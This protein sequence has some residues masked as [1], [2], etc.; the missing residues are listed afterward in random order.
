MMNAKATPKPKATPSPTPKTRV[1]PMQSMTEQQRQDKA[2][3]DLMKKRAETA[4]KTG[5]W[6]NY[7]TN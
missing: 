2:L 5:N 3:K 6:P 1:A 4:K 7:N